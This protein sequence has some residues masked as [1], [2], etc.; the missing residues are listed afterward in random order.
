M[1]KFMK[2]IWLVCALLGITD[3]S[4]AAQIINVHVTKASADQSRVIF[5]LSAPAAHNI[6]TLDSPLRLVI[7]LKN[8]ELQGNITDI[9]TD[10]SLFKEVRTAPRGGND[11]RFVFD[12]KMNVRTKSYLAKPSTVGGAYQ[13]IVDVFSASLPAA[14]TPTVSTTPVPTPIPAVPTP[15]PVTPP[16]TPTP[17]A[18]PAPSA[19]PTPIPAPKLAPRSEIAVESMKVAETTTPNNGREIII[20]VDAGHGGIDPGASGRYGTKEKDVVLA[21]A[22][23]LAQMIST[24]PGMRAVLIRDG[25]YFLSLRKR[26]DLAR[27][28]Q[29]DLF[30]SIHADADAEKTSGSHG[31]SVY[32]LSQRGAS[33]EAAHWL[34]EKENAADLIGGVSLNDKDE[35]LAS[36]LLDLSQSGT[37][38]ASAHLAQS[39]LGSLSKIGSMH[40]ARVQQAGFMVLRSPDIPSIL[41][42]TAFISNPMEE[43]KLNNAQARQRMAA[44]VFQGIQQ[45]FNK[46]PAVGLL[47]KR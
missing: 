10:H 16:T 29:A 22:K 26:I 25:D 30:V 40:Y 24:Q 44:A 6:F 47:A 34:A 3:P 12:L 13:L 43:Q 5:E 23:E 7:D 39:V 27:Q 1:N 14:T 2:N 37:L 11:W 15:A 46:Y 45:Y 4:F 9:A 28:H 8:V 18:R 32:M 21:L 20:A 31:S 33:S 35:L 41:V 36:V 17:V 42:E 38:E 19:A